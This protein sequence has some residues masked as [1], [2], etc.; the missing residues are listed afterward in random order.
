MNTLFI[1][2][3]VL[4]CLNTTTATSLGVM[5][6]KCVDKE[7]KAVLDFKALILQDPKDQLSLWRV[8][9]E[10]DD[11]CKWNGV[12]CDSQTGHVTELRLG[13][14][15]IKGEISSSLLN[16]TY[17]TRLDLPGTYYAG[18]IP[19]STGV[20]NE[21][22]YVKLGWNNFNGIIPA[23]FGNNI[24]HTSYTIEYIDWLYNDSMPEF[25]LAQTKNWENAS[26][27]LLKLTSISLSDCELSQASLNSSSSIVSIYLG[28]NS[29]EGALPKA[30]MSMFYNRMDFDLSSCKLGPRFPLWIQTFNDILSL[31]IANNMIS[32][33]IPT[34]FWNTWDSRLSY[35]NVSSNNISG[36]VLDLKSN[37]G[38]YSSI[39]LS[40]NNFSGPIQNVSSTVQLL[41]LSKNKFSGGISFICQI[42]SGVLNF[43]DLSDNSF[44]GKIPNCCGISKN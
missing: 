28:N 20:L 29:P 19:A 1:L 3:L 7:R 23:Q 33:T 9:K 43:L 31:S 32:D 21:I 26:L 22:T 24:N 6:K 18:I 15:D 39:D 4:L 13:D 34:D 17:L 5:N 8:E 11:C 38:L 14:G 41:N 12:M 10:S 37:F 25:S 36:Q 2:S 16:L 30:D 42:V 40:S 35:L 44:T 27:S